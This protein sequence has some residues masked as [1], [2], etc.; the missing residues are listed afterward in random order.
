MSAVSFTL[1]QLPAN[2]SRKTKYRDKTILEL[3]AMNDTPQSE[4]TASKKIERVSTM[5]KWALS[6]KK[7]WGIDYEVV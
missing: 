4:T 5:F 3:L 7:K 2:I 1:K 6:E